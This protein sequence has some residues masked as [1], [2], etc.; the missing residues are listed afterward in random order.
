MTYFKS[1]KK[2]VDDNFMCTFLVENAHNDLYKFQHK[3]GLNLAHLCIDN[4][5]QYPLSYRLSQ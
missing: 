3:L 2:R 4:D 1:E 5:W